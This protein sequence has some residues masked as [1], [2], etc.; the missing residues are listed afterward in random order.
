MELTELRYIVVEG[1]IGAGKTSL[2]RRLGDH[3]RAE[4]VFERA[5]DNPFLERFYSDRERYALATQLNFLFQRADQLRPLAQQGLFTQTVVGDFLLDKDPIFARLTLSDDEHALYTKVY[6]FLAPQAP[7]PDLVIVLQA[8]I[9]NLLARIERRGIR[10]ERGIERDYL[11][12]LA[13][14]YARHFHH[15][16]RAPTLF[17]NTDE[18]NFVDKPSHLSLLLGK[19]AEMRSHREFFSMTSA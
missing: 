17:V 10:Y 9:E 19:I 7:A 2:A 5:S 12:R 14:A 3:L 16:D 1:V 13:D 11:R 4:T 15:Y 8:S 6:E 18:L